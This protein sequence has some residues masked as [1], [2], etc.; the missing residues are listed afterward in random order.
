LGV[1][2]LLL[3]VLLL[4]AS[5]S[6]ARVIALLRRLLGV[7]VLAVAKHMCACRSMCPCMPPW[8]GMTLLVLLLHL[9]ARC[10]MQKPGGSCVKALL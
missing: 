3:L 8:C 10:C 4:G 9:M 6:G 7:L 1:T 2:V 5:A